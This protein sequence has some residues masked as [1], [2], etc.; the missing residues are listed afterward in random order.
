MDTSIF[1]DKTKTPNDND[2]KEKLND[3]FDHW[4]TIRKYLLEKYPTGQKEWNYSGE[5]YG[6]S[7]RIKDNHR[8]ILYLLPRDN[9][10]KAAFV[11]GPKAISQI[12]DSKISG[13]IKKD[14]ES[15][16]AYSEGRGIRI[17]IKEAGII[18][19]IKALIDIKLAN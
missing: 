10:F 5:K 8:V 7:F 3:T 11:F 15:A 6:W 19:D 2:L 14:L 1:T 9:Y 18:E 12:M 17:D 16:T 4:Q 13:D